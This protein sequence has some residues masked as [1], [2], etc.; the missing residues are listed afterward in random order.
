VLLGKA[1]PDG[2]RL[3]LLDLLAETCEMARF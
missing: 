3:W 2:G 1:A